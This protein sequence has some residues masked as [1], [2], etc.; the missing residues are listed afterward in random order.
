MHPT[1]LVGAAVLSLVLSGPLAAQDAAIYDARARSHPVWAEHGMVVSEEA[2]ATRVGVDILRRGGNAVDAAV[3]VGF[4]LAVTLP[5]AGNLGGGGF[6][7]VRMADGRSAAVDYRETATRAAYRDMYLDPTGKP[8][9]KLSQYHGL[10]VGVPGTVA[11]LARALQDYG[12]MTL[13][14]VIAPALALAETG[15]EVTP[16]LADSLRAGSKRLTAWPSTAKIFFKP[17]GSGPAPGET[18]KQPDL[19]GSLRLVAEQGPD[20]FYRGATAERIAAEVRKAGGNM[21]VE[22]LAGYEVK[23]REPVKGSYR[24][25]EILSMPPPSSGGIH[26]IQILNLLEPFPIGWL[27]HNSAETIHLMA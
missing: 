1:R 16:D 2:V 20:G 6:M 4:A 15:I 17:D 10:A 18:L 9:S 19:A 24:G 13:P 23:I 27:G 25:H 26:I 8:D 22:D 7:L 12:T 14:Q 5:R 3:A 11:G 21:T